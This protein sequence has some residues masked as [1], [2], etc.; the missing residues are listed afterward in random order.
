M[1]LT[2]TNLNRLFAWLIWSCPLE[3][4]VDIVPKMDFIFSNGQYMERVL[5]Y[6]NLHSLAQGLS[7]LNQE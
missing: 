2:P 5:C 4:F 7:I 6:V 3:W 1:F